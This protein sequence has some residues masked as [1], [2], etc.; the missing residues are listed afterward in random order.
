MPLYIVGK[1]GGN[2]I[3]L[4][5]G[6]PQFTVIGSNLEALVPTPNGITTVALGGFSDNS[7]AI[8]KLASIVSAI[9]PSAIFVATL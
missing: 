8:A 7:T 4:Q 5:A 2:A 9:D 3:P 6:L 1:G